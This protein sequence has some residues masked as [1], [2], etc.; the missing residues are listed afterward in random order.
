MKIVL[1]YDF[2]DGQTGFILLSSSV[3]NDVMLKFPDLY[4]TLFDS[5][6]NPFGVVPE[7]ITVKEY[8]NAELI[9]TEPPTGSIPNW[10][11]LPLI[12]VEGT[13]LRTL[14]TYEKKTLKVI[15]TYHHDG[16]QTYYWSTIQEALESGRFD[17]MEQ[18][19][20]DDYVDEEDYETFDDLIKDS[21]DL[22]DFIDKVGYPFYIEE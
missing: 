19:V 15:E 4:E 17:Y 16:D 14:N 12:V 1:E 7:R 13:Y 8:E 2:K 10:L 3:W 22:R 6:V 11:G 5:N 18:Q 20:E 9:E 21:K